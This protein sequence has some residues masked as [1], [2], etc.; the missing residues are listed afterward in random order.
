[1][2]IEDDGVKLKCALNNMKNSV[3]RIWAALLE[4]K[5]P[6]NNPKLDSGTSTG[7]LLFEN[8]IMFMKKSTLIIA[9]T[10]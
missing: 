3:T 9:S 5:W 7:K 2:Q 6:R 1:M 8:E 4:A 10:K